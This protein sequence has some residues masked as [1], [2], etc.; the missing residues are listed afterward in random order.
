MTSVSSGISPNV[1]AV[2]R[3]GFWSIGARLSASCPYHARTCSKNA[4]R[5]PVVRTS[6]P[7]GP[8]RMPAARFA[9]RLTTSGFSR[10]GGSPSSGCS[11]PA[12]SSA[13]TYR[14]PQAAGSAARVTSPGDAVGSAR[15]AWR[16][17][18]A[19]PRE[20]VTNSARVIEVADAATLNWNGTN[21]CVKMSGTSPNRDHRA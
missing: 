20:Y 2:N 17:K 7:A 11:S 21:G 14:S 15:I 13:A 19:W 18:S 5:S 10:T 8:A 3:L 4:G 9:T 16:S 12:S 1:G 6:C